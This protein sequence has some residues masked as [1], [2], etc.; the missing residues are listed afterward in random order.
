MNNTFSLQQISRTGNL[1]SQLIT[2]QYKLNLIADFTRIKHENPKLKQSEIA[3][4]LGYSSSTSQRYRNDINM[5]SPYRIQPDNT[6]K[7]TK[8]T[9]NTKSDNNSQ[10]DDDLK[11]PQM[12]SSD[13]NK[14]ETTTKS[15]R[16][17]NLKGGS[18]QE[19]IEINDQFLDEIL[20]KKSIKFG[21]RIANNLC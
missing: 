13:P 5:L 10:R 21:F 6:R 14:P 1:D 20:D 9:S 19:N 12:T 16:K 15:N 7:R 8:K 17:S 3:N 11:R 4:P 2:K 18:I